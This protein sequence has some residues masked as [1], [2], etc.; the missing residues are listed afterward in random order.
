M[1]LSM[2]YLGFFTWVCLIFIGN[3]TFLA[4]RWEGALVSF[5][6]FLIVPQGLEL[7]IPTFS[8]QKNEQILLYLSSILLGIGYVSDVSG[9]CSLPYLGM[10]IWFFL[11]EMVHFWQKRQF[12]SENIVAIFALGYLVTGALWA[13]SLLFRVSPL[14]FDAVI[15]SLTAAHFHLAG[16]TLTVIIREL[17]AHTVG[18]WRNLLITTALIGMSLVALGITLTKFQVGISVEWMGSVLFGILVLIIAVLQGKIAWQIP[19]F[20]TKIA[21][22]FS[23]ICLFFGVSLAILYALRFIY[24][25][26][27]VTIPNMKLWHGTL[28]TLGFGFLGVSGWRHLRI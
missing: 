11:K 19:I 21:L 10:V 9:W 18:F 7:L 20:P 13:S 6:T 3:T 16:F 27:W 1:K 22:L 28:N 14:G 5:A 12:L 4:T 17:L 25:I 2:L 23:S 26:S 15:V 8:K 24:P